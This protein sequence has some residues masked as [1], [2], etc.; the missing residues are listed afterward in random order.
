[1][2]GAIWHGSELMASN[3]TNSSFAGKAFL[4]ALLVSVV[5]SGIPIV[6]VHAHENAT[7]GHSHDTHDLFDHHGAAT[8]DTEDGA[9]DTGS[10]HAHDVNAVSLGILASVGLESTVSRHS[11]SHI[12]PPY[13]QLPD[14]VVAPLYR[15]PIA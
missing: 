4:A 1:M 12:P 11:H 10:F 14:S 2:L 9:T 7:H 5:L 15:P 8:A 3:S 13:S 6:E